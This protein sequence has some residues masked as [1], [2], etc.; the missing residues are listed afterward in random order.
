MLKLKCKIAYKIFNNKWIENDDPIANNIYILLDFYK[1]NYNLNA[2]LVDK[3]GHIMIAEIGSL[4]IID[5]N[6]WTEHSLKNLLNG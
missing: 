6:L 5:E 1:A 4:K 3:D 2:I